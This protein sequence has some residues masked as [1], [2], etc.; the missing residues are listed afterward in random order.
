MHKFSRTLQAVAETQLEIIRDEKDREERARRFEE[1]TAAP[2]GEADEN[3]SC[4][5][6]HQNDLSG[7]LCRRLDE[8]ENRTEAVLD[9]LR[10]ALS[11][12]QQKKEKSGG[13]S[14]KRVQG[15]EA[16]LANLE[17]N[18]GRSLANIE[19]LLR[20]ILTGREKEEEAEIE[21]EEEEREKRRKTGRRSFL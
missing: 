12:Q 18:T 16:R 9:N 2:S 5:S 4:A 7:D 17:E 13:V 20:R 15:L 1:E 14:K 6:D 19:S 10:L 21:R 8:F 3:L 11:E